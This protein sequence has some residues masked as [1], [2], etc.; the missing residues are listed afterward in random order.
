MAAHHDPAA[1]HEHKEE[2]NLSSGLL[3]FGL[4]LVWLLIVIYAAH[5]LALASH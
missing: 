1:H 4:G 3:G 2:S 5:L